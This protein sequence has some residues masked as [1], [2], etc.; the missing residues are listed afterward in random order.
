MVRHGLADIEF[1]DSYSWWY[2]YPFHS[3]FK[4]LDSLPVGMNGMQF[5]AP[6]IF[7]LPMSNIGFVFIQRC[8]GAP[9]R[10]KFRIP[11]THGHE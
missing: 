7:S 8:F 4:L 2:W 10:E 11:P 6:Q 3:H 5:R 9:A 1:V